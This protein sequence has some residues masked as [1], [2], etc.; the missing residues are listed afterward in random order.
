MNCSAVV[1]T[2]DINDQDMQRVVDGEWVVNILGASDE[3]G[4]K[5]A[6]KPFVQENGDKVE[7]EFQSI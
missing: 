1:S 3:C 6:Q 4:I 2:I 5:I 7:W